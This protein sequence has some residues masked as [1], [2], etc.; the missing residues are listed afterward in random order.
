MAALPANTVTHWYLILII[1]CLPKPSIDISLPLS[2]ISDCY[3]S[4][5]PIEMPIPWVLLGWN[6]WLDCKTIS[7]DISKLNQ[8][9]WRKTDG[10]NPGKQT[11]GVESELKCRRRSNCHRGKWLLLVSPPGGAGIENQTGKETNHLNVKE[12]PVPWLPSFGDS[13][14][15]R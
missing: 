5:K 12:R 11:S 8:Q 13:Q 7:A 15:P 4:A 3:T 10:T 2:P 1:L 6:A 14:C 9:I